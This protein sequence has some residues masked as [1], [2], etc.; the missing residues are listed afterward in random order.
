MARLLSIIG[1]LRWLR[2]VPRQ[3]GGVKKGGNVVR[4]GHVGT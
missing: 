2:K 4:L 1:L 3:C